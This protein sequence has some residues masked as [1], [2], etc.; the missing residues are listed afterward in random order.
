MEAR[1]G[2]G[3]VEVSTGSDMFHEVWGKGE[4]VVAWRMKESTIR[5]VQAVEESWMD[6][7]SKMSGTTTVLGL[8][9]SAPRHDGEGTR[10]RMVPQGC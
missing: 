5:C 2:L 6:R 7:M 1:G 9:S 4:V 10:W 3:R 8:C